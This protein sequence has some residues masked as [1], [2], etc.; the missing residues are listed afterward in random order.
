MSS[1]LHLIDNLGLGGAQT[2]LSAYFKR[3]G[4]RENLALFSL[5][6]TDPEMDLQGKN[7]IVYPSRSRYSPFPIFFILNLIWSRKIEFVHCHL[8]RSQVFGLILKLIFPG[9]LKLVFH[10][11]GDVLENKTLLFL[12]RLFGQQVHVFIACSEFIG[13]ALRE[14]ANI[15][16][17]RVKVIHNCF[18]LDYFRQEDIR[19]DRLSQRRN[20]GL[21]DNDFVIGFAARLVERKGWK[22]FLLVARELVNQPGIVFLVAG[23]GEDFQA[24]KRFVMENRLEKKVIFLG[25]VKKM[26]SFYS[27]LDLFVMPSHFEPMGIAQIEAQSMRVPVIASNVSGLN[28]VVDDSNVL[29]IEPGNS[30]ALTDAIRQMMSNADLKDSLVEQGLKN[31]R[32]YSVDDF[33]SNLNSVIEEGLLLA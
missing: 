33:S 26:A 32:K 17:E 10:E 7:V 6:R 9:S 2:V 19:C 23:T 21:A 18:D 31:A 27:L 5:R 29:F 25:Y 16:P 20:L 12:L 28:E 1:T 30:V 22:E 8:P 15:T 4:S 24:M 3:Q 14:M 13:K 11:Q